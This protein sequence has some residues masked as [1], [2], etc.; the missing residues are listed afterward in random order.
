[1]SPSRTSAL[2]VMYPQPGPEHPAYPLAGECF[3][4]VLFDHLHRV[5]GRIHDQDGRVMELRQSL[6]RI[7]RQQQADVES[8]YGVHC[9]LAPLPE[10]VAG[11]LARVLW[12]RD[13]DIQVKVGLEQ[14]PA[15]APVER[16]P[17]REEMQA[18]LEQGSVV[19]E[20]PWASRRLYLDEGGGVERPVTVPLSTT[21]AAA[22][23][24]HRKST[25]E[26]V[27]GSLNACDKDGV[28]ISWTASVGSLEEGARL[29][30][31]PRLAPPPLLRHLVFIAYGERHER[32]VP[33]T[34]TLGDAAKSLVAEL[35]YTWDKQELRTE[36]GM[37]MAETL[38]AGTFEDG[39]LV[40]ICLP[41]GAGG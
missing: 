20:G 12:H 41:V 3:K 33:E 16:T 5:L 35:G 40:H 10:P 19:L 29:T 13:L 6:K 39:M 15:Y 28:L 37:L 24:W 34:Q 7:S 18:L 21:L 1:M 4:I 32:H 26:E 38:V 31:S 11:E 25:P 36:E 14:V 9:T 23:A 17:A 27:S 8:M 22:V 30:L 2:P